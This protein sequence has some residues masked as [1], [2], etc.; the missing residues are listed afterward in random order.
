MMI[1]KYKDE[2]LQS[3]LDN[4]CRIYLIDLEKDT[5]VKI[6]EAEGENRE[7]PVKQKKYSEF[8]RIY[9]YSMLE[10]EYSAWR[11]MMGSIENIRKVLADRN[12]FTVSY[13]MKDGRWMKVEN[14]ILEKKGGVPVKVFACIPKEEKGQMA[15]NEK[16]LKEGHTVFTSSTER[17]LAEEREK[18]IKGVLAFDSISTFEINV[19]RNKVISY[20]NRNEDLYYP[21]EGI[22][23]PGDY[24]EHSE[25]WATRIL[26][27]NADRF[28][29]LVK[30]ENLIT[31]YGMG[32][33]DP[34]I[35]YMVQDKFG[36]RIWLR[37][38]IALSKNEAT[39]DIMAVIIMRDIT[40][41]KK[42]EFENTRRMD[43]IMGLTGDYESVYFVDLE[44]D[45]YDIYRRQDRI[46]TK[47]SSIF[48]PSYSDSIEAFAYKGVYGQDR[49]NFIRLL[50]ID[51]IRKTLEKK[52]G[53]SFSFRAGNS[54]FPQYYLVKCVRIGSGRNIQILLGFANIEEERQEE[55]RKRRLLEDA[56]EQA[57]HA[58]DAKNTFLSN[59]SHDIRTPMNAII[60]FAN[61]ARAHS[62]DPDRVMDSLNKIIASSNHLLQLINNVLDMSRIESGRMVLE[63][64]WVDIREIVQEVTDLIK[65]E[66]LSHR[67][68]YEFRVAENI[69]DYVLCDKLRVTQL[70]LNLL[71]NAVKYTPRQGRVRLSLAE[72]IGA[73]VGYF[74][75][76]FVISDTGIGMS[77][78][79]QKRIFEPFERENN[80]TVS[81]VMGSGLG[82]SICKGIVDSMGGS[83]TIDSR[84]GRG[85]VVTVNLAMRYKDRESGETQAAGILPESAGRETSS[86]RYAVFSKADAPV[87]KKKSETRILVVE[88]N[89]LNREIAKELLEDEG[90]LVET[91]EDGE[92]SINMIRRSDRGYF[93]AVLMDIQMPG[94][95]GYEAARSIRK[96]HDNEHARLPIIAM[97]ANA[98][99]EDMERARSAGM[100]AY[101][102]KPVEPE[103]IKLVL[104]QV[105]TPEDTQ[106]DI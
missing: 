21:V 80:S 94:I 25:Y 11:E 99:E 1:D 71:S 33:R 13:Q 46:M 19:T 39:G 68:E 100:N 65:P 103:A 78:E 52:N 101:I 85:S 31:M 98:F 69:P 28:R 35:E 90:Y 62:D 18:L 49:E 72:G 2:L 22:D 93:D 10:P 81:K 37:E 76:E 20:I 102:A 73:P 66:I 40:E 16:I 60:G 38:I 32:E 56:L 64:S 36:N 50:S 42:I 23:I 89:A 5:I 92:T 51:S 104:E 45:S 48:L 82:M 3:F 79:F 47:Y 83:M 6:L 27:D 67:H 9:S 63:E 43:L 14:R 44:T 41:R 30:R 57:R 53:F 17:K 97:T 96:M 7:D 4:Y 70:L 12:S 88:D 95:D 8:N 106:D 84:Q 24:D 61:I 86:S 34:W 59:M 54:A 75:L 15:E 58:A 26:S 74:A 105:M 55:L 77:K 87:K 91:A 29:E